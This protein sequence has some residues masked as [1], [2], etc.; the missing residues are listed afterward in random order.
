MGKAAAI[1]SRSTR[2]ITAP[3]AMP[4]LSVRVCINRVCV[5]VLLCVCVCVY[6]HVYVHVHVLVC[7]CEN[8]CLQY[9][10]LMSVTLVPAV[11]ACA[12]MGEKDET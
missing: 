4:M 2:D 8:F 12:C 9:G 5:C 6:V 3:T 11:R 1:T 10:I 7:V